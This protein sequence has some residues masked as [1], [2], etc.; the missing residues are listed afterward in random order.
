MENSKNVT[1]DGND[2]NFIDKLQ[3]KT[4]ER[5]SS[6]NLINPVKR[7]SSFNSVKFLHEEEIK[8]ITIKES[9]KLNCISGT[10]IGAEE[11]TKLKKRRDDFKEFHKKIIIGN[12]IWREKK[13]TEDPNYFQKL[14]R[15]QSPKYLVI[16]CSDSRVV[17]NEFIQT[18]PGDVFTHRN[19]GNLVVST[20]FNCQSVIQFAIEYLKVEHILVI[21]HTD[22]GAVKA[23][24][25]DSH[26]GLIDHW[27]MKIRHVAEKHVN[28]LNLAQ[29]KEEILRGLIELNI[30]EQ[31]LNLCKN[32]IIQKA[33]DS[34]QNLYIHGCI[35]EMESG[36]LKELENLQMEWK[37]VQEIYKFK[38]AKEK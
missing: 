24:L 33:W 28:L 22:C 17:V 21:G 32:P 6:D 14:S 30:R 35:F 1:K 15:P 36:L 10:N 31:C 18:E 5:G 25:S 37:E 7:W 12:K 3:N 2:L 9:V 20:D 38:F 29:S 27:F 16:A 26:H 13:I 34:G 19:I 23:A 8:N 4:R 11:I